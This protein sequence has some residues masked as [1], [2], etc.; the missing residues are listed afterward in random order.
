MIISIAGFG[1]LDDVPVNEMQPFEK[2]FYKYADKNFPHL[3]EKLAA[4][5]KLSD[6]IVDLLKK[7][8]EGYKAEY[9]KGA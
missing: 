1:Y 7:A 9:K 8:A 4:E 2:G 6:D 5:K 3:R